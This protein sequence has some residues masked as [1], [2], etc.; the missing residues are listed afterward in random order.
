MNFNFSRL[1]IIRRSLKIIYD[2]ITANTFFDR[3]KETTNL[4]KY[5]NYTGI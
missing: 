3:H 5:L 1:T 2:V 4:K